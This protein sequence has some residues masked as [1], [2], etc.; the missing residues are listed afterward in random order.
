MTLAEIG[1]KNDIPLWQ[2]NRAPGWHSRSRVRR[3]AGRRTRPT[4]GRASAV[5]LGSAALWASF[6]GAR[7]EWRGVRGR[8]RQARASQNDRVAVPAARTTP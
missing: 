3:A 7:I 8:R 5:G 4:G 2:A 1:L 6:H